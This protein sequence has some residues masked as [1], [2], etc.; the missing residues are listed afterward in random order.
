MLGTVLGRLFGLGGS[1]QLA[2][3]RL[4]FVLVQD[5]A[6]L[7]NEELTQFK[8]ELVEVIQR[9]FVIADKGFDISYK[10]GGDSTTLLI[11]SPIIVKR[12]SAALS[13][14]GVSRNSSRA[15]AAKMSSEKAGASSSS[16][17][18]SLQGE[19]F[20]QGAAISK[21]VK[22]DTKE[23]KGEAAMGSSSS[24]SSGQAKAGQKLADKVEVDK[25][26]SASP[27]KAVVQNI[28]DTRPG[29]RKES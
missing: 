24:G 10:R 21:G 14:G 20:E 4:Q 29:E 5:R 11:N 12:E 3:N 1:K 8:K 26:E 17:P 22:A 13:R 6:G 16:K 15:H 9:Y 2:K 28:S 18:A 23:A 19:L 27:A 25:S 7:T